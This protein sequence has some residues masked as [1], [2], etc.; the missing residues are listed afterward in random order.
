M[1]KIDNTYWGLSNKQI[2]FIQEQSISMN[3]LDVLIEEI[4]ILLAK[5]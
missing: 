2:D 1:E 4:N 3:D 5:K